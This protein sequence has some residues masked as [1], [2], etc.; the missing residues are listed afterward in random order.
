MW[1]S[2]PKEIRK[3]EE[4]RKLPRPGLGRES[5]GEEGQGRSSKYGGAECVQV[6]VNSACSY[7]QSTVAAVTPAKHRD[8]SCSCH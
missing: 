2:R 7:S 8:C 3:S 6:P 5:T 4:E 1:N